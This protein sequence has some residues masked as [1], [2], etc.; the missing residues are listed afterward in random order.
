VAYLGSFKAGLRGT[1][2]QSDTTVRYNSTVVLRK[3]V[4]TD[5]PTGGSGT[6]DI[7]SVGFRFYGSKIDYEVNFGGRPPSAT[8]EMR[9]LTRSTLS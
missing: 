4:L 8:G 6:Y 7:A 9:R 3:L 2:G 5:V 1:L